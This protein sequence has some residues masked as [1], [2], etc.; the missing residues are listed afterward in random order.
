MHRAIIVHCIDGHEISKSDSH[1]D[2]GIV[3]SANM[4]WSSHYDYIVSKAYRALGLLRRSLYHTNS[5]MIKKIMYLHIVRSCL[6]YCSPLWRPHQVYHITFLERVQR[7]ASKFILND[8]TMDYKSRLIN[9]NLLPLMYIYELTDILFF[10]KSIQIPSNSFETISP[11]LLSFS[12]SNTRLSGIKLSHKSS[13]NN[14]TLNSY[15]FRLPRLWNSL[16]V[17]DCSF[18]F[19]IIKKK[20][21]SFLWN[22]FVTNFDSNNNCTFHFLCPCCKCIKLPK[23]FNFTKL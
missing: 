21:M 5:V 16:P 9:L 14:T 17:I 22:H 6:L 13:N 4:S 12:A 8:Y 15:F 11:D 18:P 19:N 3:F 1:R 10:I 2:L 20:L 7:R 23:H